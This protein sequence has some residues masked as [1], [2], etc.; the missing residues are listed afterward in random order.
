VARFDVFEL[1]G[2]RLVLDVQSDFLLGIATRV[3]V[4]LLP[5]A[6]APRPFPRLNPKFEI[7]NE[8]YVMATTLVVAVPVQA[9]ATKV[10]S[11]RA[12]QDQ[13]SRALD[14]VFFGA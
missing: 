3:V 11:L 5:A 1:S 2:S 12:E 14:M 8:D 7:N 10:A 6:T 4:P 13:I 9:L